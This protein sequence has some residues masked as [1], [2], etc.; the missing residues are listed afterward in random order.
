MLVIS[1][2]LHNCQPSESIAP[3]I[4]F[5]LHEADKTGLDFSNDLPID[6]SLNIINYMYYYNGGGL[7]AGDFNND[8]LTDLFFTSNLGTDALYLNLGDLK[9]KDIT[10][11]TGLGTEENGWSTGVAIVDINGDGLLDLYVCQVGKYRHLNSKNK[12]F[13]CTYIDDNDIPHY[14]DQAQAYGLDF[15][16]FSTQAG[17]FDYD[18]DGDLD[19]FLM[20]HALHHDG[21]FDRREK[22]LNQQHS[23]S[24]DRLYRNDG[25]TFTDVTQSAG[26]L[27]HGIGYGLG[28][29]F[30]DVNADGYPDIYVANDF[31]ENDY[32]YINQQNGQFTEELT[33]QLMHSSRYSMGTDIGDLNNDGWP[34]IFTLDMLPENADILKRSEAEESY[35]T[36]KFRLDYG[37]F[38]Q[39]PMNSLQINQGNNSYSEIARYSGVNASDWSWS[40]IIGDWDMDG[41]KDLFISNGIPKRMNDLDFLNYISNLELRKDLDIH[42]VRMEDLTMIESI[43]EI[44]IKNKFYANQAD[45]RFI[46]LAPT[47]DNDQNSYSNSAVM[48][49]F[50]NDGDYDIVTNNINQLAFLYENTFAGESISIRL[51]GSKMNHFGIGAKI[52]CYSNGDL[53]YL[54]HYNTKAFQSSMMT[55]LLFAKKGNIDSVIVVWPGGQ[56]EKMENVEGGELLFRYRESLPYKSSHPKSTSNLEVQEVSHRFNLDLIHHENPFIEFNRQPLIPHSTSDLGPGLAVGDINGDGLDDLFLG[57]AKHES[58]SLMIQQPDG[59]FKNMTEE[60][61]HLDVRCEQ[62]DAVIAD[63]NNDGHNDLLIGNGGNEFYLDS[64]VNTPQ[65]LINDGHGK[66]IESPLAFQDIRITASNLAV[67]DYDNDNDLDVFIGGRAIPYYYGEIPTSYLLNNDGNGLFSAVATSTDLDSIGMVKAS[68]WHDIDKDGDQDLL[69]AVEWDGIYLFTNNNGSFS[70]SMITDKKGWWNFIKVFDYDNDGDSDILLGNL[71]LNSRLKASADQ[72][73]RMYYG[74]FG[75]SAKKLPILTYYIGGK[76]IPFYTV[77]DI[78]KQIPSIKDKFPLAKDFAQASIVDLLGKNEINNSKIFEANYLSNAVLINEDGHYRLQ[79]LPPLCQWTPYH[80]AVVADFNS[81]GNNDFFMVGNYFGNSVQMGRYDADYGSL[82]IWNPQ[83]SKFEKMKLSQP[84]LKGQGRKIKAITI[85]G[86]PYYAVAMNNDS[87]KILAIANDTTG[88]H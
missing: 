77:M 86:K 75:N 7:A 53:Q 41:Y 4:H 57:S 63:F 3:P 51:E 84:I 70:Q 80:D 8:G 23:L 55:P 25:H 50:D 88:H 10:S 45:L 78:I 60:S 69:V 47:I 43:P 40:P 34:D 54:E 6:T 74:N 20:N 64:P 49:D 82:M 67:A 66:L 22:F 44:K 35:H 87:L 27:S 85:K 17:F 73:I 30:S 68:I 1:L 33:R 32:L 26:I 39:Y 16:G 36:Y 48:A 46:D 31:H 79:D 28:L 72:P 76:E 11:L 62:V 19:M 58:P 15:Q 5:I 37:Y 42:R 21:K 9:F 12:L 71:G 38:H 13:I 83:G 52:Y 59:S 29:S 81:D 65:L 18:L 14:E 61:L 24:G 2:T 56:Y